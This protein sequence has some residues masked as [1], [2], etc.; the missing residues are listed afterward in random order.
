[1]DWIDT[2]INSGRIGSIE[3]PSLKQVQSIRQPGLIVDNCAA[4]VFC[5]LRAAYSV[6]F[7]QYIT[8]ALSPTEGAVISS[9]IT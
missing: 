4:Q 6:L 1:M 9:M 2:N 8:T 7:P 3:V 5:P